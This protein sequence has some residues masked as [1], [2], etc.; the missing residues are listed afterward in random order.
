[1]RGCLQV[2]LAAPMGSCTPDM[3]RPQEG[4][5][6]LKEWDEEGFTPDPIPGMPEPSPFHDRQPRSLSNEVRCEA[7]GCLDNR[8]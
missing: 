6:G 8:R 2:W 3:C 5:F 1:M 7:V 4:Q